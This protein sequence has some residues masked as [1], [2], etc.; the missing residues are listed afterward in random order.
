MTCIP[1]EAEPSLESSSCYPLVN[2]TRP[3]CQ[4]FGITLPSYVYKTPVDQIYKN[5]LANT[6]ADSFERLGALK[7]SHYF[8]VDVARVRKCVQAA[9]MIYC[10]DQFPSCDRTEN[11][12]MEQKVCREP[13]LESIRV[14]GKMY[15]AGFKYLIMADPEKKKKFRCELQPYRNAG[16][17]PECYY[18]RV[19]TNSTGKTEDIYI[20]LQRIM[21]RVLDGTHTQQKMSQN[22]QL[23]AS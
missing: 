2:F 21:N 18:Y 14:C 15:D 3:F 10:H 1:A 20:V 19:R 5:D 4:N 8:N 6:D 17:S 23:V 12:A 7:V 22:E 16:D 13:C 11:V 9:V